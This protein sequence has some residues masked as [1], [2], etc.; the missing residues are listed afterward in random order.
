MKAGEGL[1]DVRSSALMSTVS[2]MMLSRKNLNIDELVS[3][4]QSIQ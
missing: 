1:G 4:E 2:R 3:N